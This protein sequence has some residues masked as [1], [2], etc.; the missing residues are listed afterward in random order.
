MGKGETRPPEEGKVRDISIH[1][2]EMSTKRKCSI[3]SRS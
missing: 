2:E 3:A 1:I